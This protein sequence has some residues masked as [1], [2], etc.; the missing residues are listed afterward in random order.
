MI[1]TTDGRKSLEIPKTL[2]QYSNIAGNTL[3]DFVLSGC[4]TTFVL[5]RI[6]ISTSFKV[7][8]LDN[9]LEAGICLYMTD[10]WLHS[11]NCNLLYGDSDNMV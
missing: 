5:C 10:I 2:E 8:K 6:E 11:I 3:S 1:A 9:C 7:L 4:D